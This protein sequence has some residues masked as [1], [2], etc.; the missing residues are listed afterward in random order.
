MRKSAMRWLIVVPVIGLAACSSDDDPNG[1]VPHDTQAPTVVTVAPPEGATDLGLLASFTVTFSEAMDPATLNAQTVT[2]DSGGVALELYVSPSGETLVV[3]PDSL[4]PAEQALTL[5]LAGATDLAGNAIEPFTA[6]VTTGPLDCAHLADR[7]EPN[8]EAAAATEV[9][10]DTLYTGLSTCQDD[11]DVFRF[12]VEDTLMVAARTCIVYA[13]DDGWQILW[14][15]Q[16]GVTSAATLGTSAN[17][18]ET[19]SFHYT[20]LPGTY[21]LK[22]TGSHVEERIL[23]DLEL[24]TSAPCRDDIFEDN[25]FDDEAA[26]IVPGTYVGLTGCYLDADWY[27]FFVLAGE[28]ITFTVDT[29]AYTGTRRLI[30]REPGGEQVLATSELSAPV[31]T[32]SLPAT[33][34]GQAR[35]MCMVWQ[36]GVAYSM[37][38]EVE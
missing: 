20:F 32:L 12:T 8:E 4:L 30:I 25:D 5:A 35:V 18:G 29:G 22:L 36:D 9:M 1:T 31:S 3:R 26:G 24:E 38:I 2:L 27:S 37:M 34:D 17:T 6:T 10:L 19:P 7:F 11:V 13:N 21:G 14:E 28:T 23:Y 16:D 33:G 15:R